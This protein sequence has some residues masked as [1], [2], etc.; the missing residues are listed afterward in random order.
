MRAVLAAAI[1]ALGGCAVSEPFGSGDA[2]PDR[3][4]DVS[5]VPEPTPRD[6]PRSRYGNPESYEVNGQRY[7]VLE[8]GDGFVQRGIASWYGKKFHGRRTSSGETY[9]MYAMTAAHKELP[10]PSYVRVRNLR[11]GREITVRVND[12]GPFIDNRIIDLSYAAASRLDM[13]GDGTA[14]VEIRVVR[15]GEPNPPAKPRPAE[16]VTDT[17][18]AYYVQLGAFADRNNANRLRA[19]ARAAEPTIQVELSTTRREDG[20]ELYRVRLGPLPDAAAVDRLTEKLAAHGLVD[21][22]VTVE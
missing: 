17:D 14:P 7:H 1:L 6:E 9:D 10:L 19:R 3:P 22:H 11:N 18:V 4:R 20:A 12:R 16:P 15:P 21:T 2:P 13:L 5:D 8:S